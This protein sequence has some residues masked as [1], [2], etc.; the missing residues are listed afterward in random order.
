VRTTP[1]RL[2][3]ALAVAAL[4]PV[5]GRAQPPDRPADNATAARIADGVEKAQAGKLLDAIE[6]FQRVLDT[7]GDELVPVDRSQYTPA[8]WVVHGLI[9]RLP[10]EGVKLY[11]QRVDGQAGKRLDEARAARDD[12]GLNRLLADMFA[13]KATE[14]AILEL[15]RRA[16][17]RGDVD[18]AERLWRMLLPAPADDDHLLRFP[19]PRTPPA[20]VRARLLLVKL[21]RGDRD[22]AKAELA[23]FREKFPNESGL[24]A[25]KTGKYV[26][27]LTALLNDPS[28]TTLPRPPDEPGWPTFAGSPTRRGTNRAKLPYFWP[29]VPTW[30]VVLPFVRGNRFDGPPADPLHPRALAFFPV[31]ADG[32]AFV[33]SG[34]RILSIDLATG[35]L[36]TADWHKE[37]EEVRIP[38]RED[39]RYTMTTADG[40][41][42]ARLGP[43]AL[44]ARDGA[45][46]TSFIVCL[47]PR[48]GA[49]DERETLWR[50]D[51][52]TGGDGTFTHFEGAPLVH[53][54]RLQVGFWRQAGAEM[55]AGVACYRID[56][57]AAAPELVWQRVV[58][59]AMSEANGDTRHRHFLVTAAGPNVIYNTNGGTVISL[60]AATGKPAWEYRYPRNERPTVPRYRDLCPPLADGGRIYAA[61][62]DTDRLFCLDAATG[63][64]V[65]EREAVEVIQLLGV[66][67]GRLVATF[68][69]S[70]RGIRGLNL[71]TGA[72]SGSGGWTIHDDGGEGT[73][74]RGLVTEDVVVWPTQHGLRFL[75]PADGRQ[76]RSPIPGPSARLPNGT[77]LPGQ[78]PGP[79]GNLCY[80]GGVLV[81]TTATEVWGFVSEAKKLGDRRKAAND[82]ADNPAKR[83]DLA[84]SL[85]DAGQYAEAEA[86]AAKAGDA[87]DRL[88]W[89]LA[90]RVIRDGRRD[91]AKRLYEELAKGDGSFAAAGAARLADFTGK[92]AM[93]DDPWRAVA[94]K[95][96]AVRDERGIPWPAKTYAEMKSPRLIAMRGT[97]V[98][99]DDFVGLVDSN[100]TSTPRPE[101][102]VPVYR[103]LPDARPEPA[104]AWLS[105]Q[106]P[107]L[108]M[109]AGPAGHYVT[110]SG[111]ADITCRSR[112]DG[113]V[114]W[115][116]D[117]RPD[118]PI[119]SRLGRAVVP[120]ASGADGPPG[121]EHVRPAPETASFAYD[122]RY[123][124]EL[125][126]FEGGGRVIAAPD[127]R[128]AEL[129][130]ATSGSGAIA[131]AQTTAGQILILD[132]DGK[133]LGE[134]TCASKPWP[135][136]PPPLAKGHFLVPDD[137]SVFL[138]DAKA[139]KEL[140]RYT[141]PG[142][143]SLTGELPR[144]RIHQSDPLLLI[145]RNHGVEVE[146]LKI[147]GLKRAWDRSSVSVGR[148]LDD[149][150]FT[151]D[152]FFTAA[153]GVLAA[154]GWKDGN[155]LWQAPLPDGTWRL[156]VAPQGL[157]AY[158]TEAVLRHP[159]FDALGEFRRAGWDAAA[160]LRAASRTYDGWADR[161]LPVLV[162][163][164][165]DGRLVQR[166]TFPAA[167]PAAGVAVTPKG[168]VVVT[169]KGSWTLTARPSQ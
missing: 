113:H 48:K 160:L 6:Q 79:F 64:L 49:S 140:A 44:A 95:Q 130:P 65:W 66:A 85:I 46:R 110:T 105:S 147:D 134:Y 22:E 159:A 62:P 122:R 25:G 135:E 31:I 54:G 51:P 41:I 104:V 42:Y 103:R 73:F 152:R 86:E 131:I 120:A 115:R 47:G 27:T 20:A 137:G 112:A 132:S 146:R 114:C 68:A 28:Q 138:F 141:L 60:D 50:I 33:A 30:K 107:E 116:L 53:G 52:P 155:P 16:F 94:L 169:G 1:L 74:G 55:H 153:D 19:D 77:S 156:T 82:D 99:E 166:L 45:N 7:A 154:H 56:D 59:K 61:P 164:P 118:Q 71:W 129:H 21:F 101:P 40:L 91:E 13:A 17:E 57:P 23:V 69:G 38:V 98:A 5:S 168:V 3:L 102:P 148:T 18:D 165:A 111:P 35:R 32:R 24:L 14:E 4:V 157:L 96:G 125:V 37:G 84:Q 15:A 136:P 93:G 106:G 126:P 90:E 119:L 78:Y 143:E 150:V 43:A 9:A 36:A 142:P 29:D 8:R 127:G 139:G 128:T 76:L 2:P 89:L 151:G 162:L 81:V 88:R 67:R 158:P 100:K 34:D 63:R 75:D 83:A 124:V 97:G 133:T 109:S 72:D 145:D 80:A 167:G 87:K 121:L 149:V 39:V 11:R 144:F 58:G 10:P 70:V 163:D 12:A 123:L 92:S 117:Y 161:E 108:R 26:E